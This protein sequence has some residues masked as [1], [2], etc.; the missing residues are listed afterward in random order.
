VGEAVHCQQVKDTDFGK[1][2][3]GVA[4]NPRSG[5]G[6]RGSSVKKG[7]SWGKRTLFFG[8]YVIPL[9]NLLTVGGRM[10]VAAKDGK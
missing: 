3:V 2:R 4:E 7:F 6:A 5:V 8:T 1:K 10:A 9:I